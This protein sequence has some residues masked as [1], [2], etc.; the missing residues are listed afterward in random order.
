[1]L[2]ITYITFSLQ[3]VVSFP[4]TFTYYTYHMFPLP[5][6]LPSS[7]VFCAVLYLTIQ[8]CT[9]K[10]YPLAFQGTSCKKHYNPSFL[11]S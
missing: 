4:I 8:T 6:A 3:T 2:H 7:E 9:F 11:I 1:M 5:H 10:C